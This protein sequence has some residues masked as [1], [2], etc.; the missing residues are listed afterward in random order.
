[1]ELVLLSLLTATQMLL[2]GTGEPPTE[3]AGQGI[4]RHLVWENAQTGEKAE[5]LAVTGWTD[6]AEV[7]RLLVTSPRG[8]RLVL[9]H[10]FRPEEG[11]AVVSLAIEET[12][13]K[14]DLID[15]SDLRLDAKTA[16]DDPFQM[17]RA[18]RQQALPITRSLTLPGLEAVTVTSDTWNDLLGHQMFEEMRA[19]EQDREALAGMSEGVREEFQFLREIMDSEGPGDETL[20]FEPLLDVLVALLLS[21]GDP[22]KGP[23]YGGWD[24]QP[25]TTHIERLV[26]PVQD[27]AV[28][29]F[30]APYRTASVDDLLQGHPIGKPSPPQQQQPAP[31]STR[32]P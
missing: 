1:M 22:G 25:K 30:P 6:Q 21:E 20:R 32:P 19:R 11:L 7:N 10:T 3:L 12:S 2:A 24:A 14:A 15:R 28:A 16:L 31:D 29:R 26:Y 18:W 27:P 5:M 9:D 8:H 23:G 4:F 17:V 13:W